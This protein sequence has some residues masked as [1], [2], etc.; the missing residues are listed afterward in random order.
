MTCL[1]LLGKCDCIFWKAVSQISI[2][3]TKKTAFTICYSLICLVRQK[4]GR[5]GNCLD[6]QVKPLKC[7]WHPPD[8]GELALL[9]ICEDKVQSILWRPHNLPA[10]ESNRYVAILC[11]TNNLH[12]DAPQDIA[13]GI[14]EIE[15]T[16]TLMLMFLFVELQ[17]PH[18]CYWL[19]IWVHIKDVN[20]FLQLKCLV[21]VQLY[22]SR[23][24]LYSG[25][26][27]KSGPFLFWKN[28]PGRI[29]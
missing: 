8:E 12:L 9:G 18:D 2:W 15:T 17:L 26:I 16:F 1:Y 4:C 25:Q 22:Q 14:I 24:Q 29:G 10:V 11:G 28:S 19:I 5:K 21:F 23:H 7:G 3:L 27:T 20:K 6:R 13:D